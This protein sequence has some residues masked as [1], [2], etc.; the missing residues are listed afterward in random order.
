MNLPGSIAKLQKIGIQLYLKLAQSFNNNQL[1]RSTWLLL[2]QDLEKEAASVTELPHSFWKHLEVPGEALKE[3]ALPC[4]GPNPGET[5]IEDHSLGTCFRQT[6]NF[7]EPLIL[8]VYV[9]IIRRLRTE[10]ISQALDFYII[11]KA[12]VARLAHLVE[13]FSMDPALVHRSVLLLERFEKEVQ[14]HG[15]KAASGHNQAAKVPIAEN[16]KAKIK[17]EH[18]K[19]AAS[20]GEKTRNPIRRKQTI[21]SRTK[22]LIG[23][24]EVGRRRAQR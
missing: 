1:I 15:P 19:K 13:P 3:P 9:P 11:V 18:K 21:S 5:G 22:P 8:G 14:N 2:A 23:K 12:H 4:L 24:I 20:K 17:L 6:L 7:E 16:A 10:W